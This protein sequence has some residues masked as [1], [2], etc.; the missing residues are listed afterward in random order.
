MT[1]SHRAALTFFAIVILGSILSV[2][3][4]P[5]QSPDEIE[6]TDRAYLLSVLSRTRTP[7]NLSTGG[8]VDDGLQQYQATWAQAL[9]AKP[10]ARVSRETANQTS[11]IR[12]TRKRDYTGIPGAAPYFPLGYLPQAVGFRI[13]QTLDLGVGTSYRLARLSA[14]VA[15]AAIIAYAFSIF[16]PNALVICLLALPMT[17]F[18]ISSASA[19]GMAFAWTVLA[20][21][22]FRYGMQRDETLSAWKGALLIL[23]TFMI[24]TSRPQMVGVLVLPAAVFLARKDKRALMASIIS[25]AC[26]VGWVGYGVASTVDLRSARSVT[27]KQ[28]VNF[29]LRHPTDLVGIIWRTMTDPAT[30]GGYWR[31][32]V[33]ILGWLDRPMPT[34]TYWAAGVVLVCAVIVSFSRRIGGATRALLALAALLAV[35]LTFMALLMSWTELSANVINGVQGRYFTAPAILGAYA[36]GIWGTREPRNTGA[37]VLCAA[38]VTFS[39]TMTV[40]T[41]LWKY[42]L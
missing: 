29:Y 37:A 16:P 20:A 3:I 30:M 6:H 24:V 25:A 7:P 15:V 5:M 23:S 13:G 17:M 41:L 34:I 9:A 35:P 2:L 27:S 8:Y 36:L 1:R 38:F 21:S 33:G 4:P 19:D 39:A 32:F 42:Y 28:V 31:E 14:L 12:W 18:Q 10:D 22:L 40:S 26:A 11:V